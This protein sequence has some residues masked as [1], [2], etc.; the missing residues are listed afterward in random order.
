MSALRKLAEHQPCYLR[1]PE[2][3]RVEP[4][5]VSLAHIRRGG[6]GGTGIKPCDVNGCPACFYCHEVFDGMKQPHYTREQLDS[7]ML[8]AHCQWIEWLYK[9]EI[10]LV[11]VAETA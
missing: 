1:L 10:L 6:A 2:F 5:N 8:R 9:H 7:E 4:G 3:C 11:C